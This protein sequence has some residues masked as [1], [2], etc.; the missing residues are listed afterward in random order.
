MVINDTGAWESLRE[1]GIGAVQVVNGSVVV[2]GDGIKLLSEGVGLQDMT[3]FG[4]TRIPS[5]PAPPRLR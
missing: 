4:P 2:V 3:G 1:T 5:C